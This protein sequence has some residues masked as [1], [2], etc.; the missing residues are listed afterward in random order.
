VLH[1]DE[2]DLAAANSHFREVVN[3]GKEVSLYKGSL[4]QN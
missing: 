3:L 2:Q 1:D 4:L